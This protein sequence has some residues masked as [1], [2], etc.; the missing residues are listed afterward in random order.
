MGGPG[1]PNVQVS[2]IGGDNSVSSLSTHVCLRNQNKQPGE[3]VQLF[4]QEPGMMV[5]NDFELRFTLPKDAD[6]EPLI[7]LLCPEDERQ[8][9]ARR[10]YQ[11]DSFDPIEKRYQKQLEDLQAK[12]QATEAAKE[13]LQIERDRAREAELHAAEELAREKVEEVSDFYDHTAPPV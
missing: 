9:M 1:I 4:V 11:L 2:A 7:L 10:Y 3:E 8:E 6:A 5:V 12:N 13:Q